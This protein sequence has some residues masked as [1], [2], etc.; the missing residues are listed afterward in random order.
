MHVDTQ[1]TVRKKRRIEEETKSPWRN[2][3]SYRFPSQPP[4]LSHAKGDRS[5]PCA[6]ETWKDGDS[7]F[8]T[9]SEIDNLAND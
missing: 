4:C 6:S 3:S 2:S 1:G 7:F 9:Y 5:I 8:A